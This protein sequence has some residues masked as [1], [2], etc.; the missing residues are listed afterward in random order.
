MI[1]KGGREKESSNFPAPAR[2][3]VLCGRLYCTVLY[4]KLPSLPPLLHT[5]KPTTPSQHSTAQHSTPLPPHHN[6]TQ[7]ST[8]PHRTAQQKMA[9]PLPLFS[10]RLFQT[11][12]RLH[13]LSRARGHGS[14]FANPSRGYANTGGPR[15]GPLK[16][17]PF[18]AITLAGSGAYALMVRSRAGTGM[19]I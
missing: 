3:Y 15:N 19:L 12:S 11:P 7:H 8:A 10:R 2:T 18:V 13:H 9:Q 16:I 6:A 5:C 17:W 1:N 14:P 4:S